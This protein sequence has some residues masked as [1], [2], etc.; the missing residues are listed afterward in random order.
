MA[1]AGARE[2]QSPAAGRVGSE[3]IGGPCVLAQRSL[4]AR[5]A[6]N[7]CYTG[8]ALITHMDC[9]TKF[10][11][12]GS[13]LRNTWHKLYSCTCTL[14]VP[15]RLLCTYM[16]WYARPVQAAWLAQ[17]E[18]LRS[19]TKFSTTKYVFDLLLY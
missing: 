11:M 13:L 7:K 17:R 12:P 19:N 5:A 10:S 1:V 15:V 16:Y 9:H 14:Y 18:L 8:C 2:A 6:Q 4:L 3:L